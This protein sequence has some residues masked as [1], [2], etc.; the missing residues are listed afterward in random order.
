MGMQHFI[1][2]NMI[3]ICYY[4]VITVT[5]LFQLNWTHKGIIK[6]TKRTGAFNFHNRQNLIV[7]KSSHCHFIINFSESSFTTKVSIGEF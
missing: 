4:N 7:H 6:Y 5:K 1:V 3:D 2:I